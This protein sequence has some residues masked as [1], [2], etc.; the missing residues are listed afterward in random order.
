MVRARRDSGNCAIK[1]VKED[2][3]GICEVSRSNGQPFE[4]CR[5]KVPHSPIFVYDVR[6]GYRVLRAKVEEHYVSKLPG[7]WSADLDIYLKPNNN[8]KQ[9][10]F[11]V[12]CQESFELELFVYVPKPEAQTKSIRRATAARIQ[13]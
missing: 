5:D 1:Q 6:N 12:L 13:E 4:A 2:A 8:A 9:R 7:Q 11:E 10:Q 3:A